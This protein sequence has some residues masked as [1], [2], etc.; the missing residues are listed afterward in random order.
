ML[1]RQS[2]KTLKTRWGIEAADLDWKKPPELIFVNAMGTRETWKQWRPAGEPAKP[3]DTQ[4]QLI[5]RR[6]SGPA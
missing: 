2:F 6:P 1:A 4:Y 3:D 5:E